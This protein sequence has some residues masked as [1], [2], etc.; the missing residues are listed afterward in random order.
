MPKPAGDHVQVLVN[1]Y[2]LTGDSNRIS[3]HESR[4]LFDITA[5]GD[6]FP[7]LTRNVGD[8]AFVQEGQNIL[9]A[10]IQAIKIV[11]LGES[12]AAGIGMEIDLRMP[13]YFNWASWCCRRSS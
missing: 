6:A 9:V 7:G 4:D 10:E 12:V 1:G 13:C 5:S 11:A 8:I 3:I 2:E